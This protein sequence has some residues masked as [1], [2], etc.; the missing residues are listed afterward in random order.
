MSR[1]ARSGNKAIPFAM[2]YGFG[3]SAWLASLIYTLFIKDIMLSHRTA[4]AS[5]GLQAM[6]ALG[7]ALTFPN[8]TLTRKTRFFVVVDGAVLSVFALLLLFSN[9]VI[10]PDNFYGVH[11]SSFPPLGMLFLVLLGIH[12]LSTLVVAVYRY[13]REV[14]SR[15]YF[16]YIVLAFAVTIAVAAFTNLIL[17]LAGM[18]DL[19][20]GGPIASLLPFFAIVYALGINNINDF[21]YSLAQLLHILGRLLILACY[22][23]FGYLLETAAHMRYYSARWVVAMCVT[24]L[25]GVTLYYIFSARLQG[26]VDDRIAYSGQSPEKI[27]R[28]LMSGLG[29]EV[30]LD[31]NANYIVKSLKE[32]IGLARVGMVVRLD[33]EKYRVVGDFV[34]SKK[35]AEFIYDWMRQR[36]AAAPGQLI[37]QLQDFA[38]NRT[39]H[40]LV[41]Q[42]SIHAIIPLGS[43]TDLKGFYIFGEKYSQEI[44]TRQD[45]ELLAVITEIADLSIER[46][47]FYDKIK[48]FNETLQDRVDDATRRLRRANDKLRKLNETKDDFISMASHQLRTPLTSVKGYVSMVLDGD[49]G[50]ITRLQRRLLNQSFVSAQRMVYLISDLLNVSRLKTGKFVIEPVH[51]NLAKV[52][53]EEVEQLVETAKGRHLELAYQK[54]EHFPILMLDET[55]LRQVIMN[56]LDNAVYYTPA[57][58][59]IE[60]HLVD[61]P[62]SIEFT[63]VD[64]GIGVP[65]HEQ[66]HLFTKFFRA[67]N[68]KRARPDGTGLGLFMA[69]K[70]IIAQGGAII[71]KSQE[72]RGSTF[73]FTFAKSR[74]MAEAYEQNMQKTVD[75]K[76]EKE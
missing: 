19:S 70:V 26:V 14:Q 15:L 45:S 47:I 7:L 5:A 55:K 17:P 20:I 16:N 4:F 46:A 54:P 40:S 35:E 51:C 69:K 64:D 25:I 32:V 34:F 1:A 49:A 31:K 61:K 29:K 73:G 58:G 52:I 43:K 9:A 22:L 6:G 10:A 23:A 59:H 12:L 67:P 66:H 71:F 27:R 13:R 30:E 74:L 37:M 62:Q 56:F 50:K 8:N 38:T 57:G 41:R 2:V 48:A 21:R 28:R 36:Y 65:R 63:V 33:D 60:V 3:V 24:A 44:F 72:G 68:A 53:Q 75:L 39:A 42:K 76:S 11:L 18:T